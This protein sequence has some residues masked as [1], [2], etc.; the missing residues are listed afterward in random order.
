MTTDQY[1]HGHLAKILIRFQVISA[2]LLLVSIGGLD[3][4]FPTDYRIQAGLHGV[5]SISA[6]IV[7][8]YLTH[9][10]YILIRGVHVNFQSLRFWT[11]GATVLN[12]CGAI[13]GNWMYMRYRGESGPKE[14]ILDNVPTF[15]NVMMEFK[16]FISLFPFPL[17]L[18]VTF[19]LFYYGEAIHTRRDL[20]QF[21]G[22][23]ILVSWMFL[24]LGFV[25]GLVLAKLRF[26]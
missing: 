1:F 9:R 8:T 10:S 16:E 3:F 7:S 17:M 26:V 11:L 20:T 13:T 18:T 19:M 15:H 21:A 22:V 23:L 24:L 14:W 25:A 12:L 6:L 4:F 5:S 2:L